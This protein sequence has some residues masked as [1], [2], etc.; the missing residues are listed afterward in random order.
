MAHPGGIGASASKLKRCRL[1]GV[2]ILLLLLLLLLERQRVLD[3][4]RPMKRRLDVGAARGGRNARGGRRGGQRRRRGVLAGLPLLVV[5]VGRA[6][7]ARLRG[8]HVVGGLAR[9][10]E[11]K[12]RGRGR[13]VR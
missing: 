1:L 13:G 3:G 5:V 8:R 6:E 9:R 12:G 4:R 7:R 2:V 11:G 10:P